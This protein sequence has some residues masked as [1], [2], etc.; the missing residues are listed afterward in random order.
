M[1]GYGRNWIEVIG[2][3]WFKRK[4]DIMDAVFVL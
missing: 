3:V 1:A 2:M 4:G